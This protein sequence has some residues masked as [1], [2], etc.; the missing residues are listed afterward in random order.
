MT[1]NSPTISA[2]SMDEY[3]ISLGN[4]GNIW[5]NIPVDKSVRWIKLCSH[6]K[7]TLTYINL[8]LLYKIQHS[9]SKHKL[10]P[11]TYIHDISI[12][13]TLTIGDSFPHKLTNFNDKKYYIYRFD[14][15]LIA[16]HKKLSSINSLFNQKFIS[17]V[18][19]VVGVDSGRFVFYDYN[20]AKMYSHVLKSKHKHF[21]PDI[22]YKNIPTSQ[23]NKSTG[24]NFHKA[25]DMKL[26]PDIL[27]NKKLNLTTQSYQKLV[28][29][30]NPDNVVFVDG[31]TSVGDG[32]FGIM[33][34]S[35]NNIVIQCSPFISCVL[36][37]IFDLV[38]YNKSCN[39]YECS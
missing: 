21:V 34:N 39:I 7:N 25:K 23:C 4:D 36:N 22:P 17:D 33:F 3:T 14:Y 12:S 1:R 37:K 9:L 18:S 15:N 8:K 10:I 28:F 20:I 27:R 13:S 6:V 35:T 16:S 2:T 26:P 32:G 24:T 19:Y 31:T 5:C 30:D 38:K 29:G 11:F